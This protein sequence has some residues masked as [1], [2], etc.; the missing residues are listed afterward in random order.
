MSVF[1][2]R[3]CN[4]HWG[5]EFPFSE[6]HGGG[7]PCFYAITTDAPSLWV[8]EAPGLPERLRRRAEDAEFFS[9]LGPERTDQPCKRPG[10]PRGA[11]AQSVLCRLH[12][13][14]MVKERPC[15][16]DE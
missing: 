8:K 14:E 13:F 5:K 15:P 1:R 9:Q 16:F 3:I 11:V 6:M 2:C 12:H 7:P 4:Q 10:C